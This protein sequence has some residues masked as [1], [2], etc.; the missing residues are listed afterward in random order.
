MKMQSLPLVWSIA[1]FLVLLLASPVLSGRSKKG[2]TGIRGG[3]K[4][5]KH[6]KVSERGPK[7]V[8]SIVEGRLGRVSDDFFDGADGL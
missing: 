6:S 4:G 1:A 7:G 3:T 2:K 8:P 5:P